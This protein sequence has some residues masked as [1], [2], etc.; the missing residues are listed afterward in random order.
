MCQIQKMEVKAFKK[1]SD[2]LWEFVLG[3]VPSPSW[4]DLSTGISQTASTETDQ[5]HLRHETE[6]KV[7]VELAAAG[8][9]ERASSLFPNGY[10]CNSILAL[11]H[12]RIRLSSQVTHRRRVTSISHL[13]K[14]LRSGMFFFA[15]SFLVAL[16]GI[17]IL[18][19]RPSIDFPMRGFF[20][21]TRVRVS[22]LEDEIFANILLSDLTYK[23]VRGSYSFENEMKREMQVVKLPHDF[24]G[25]YQPQSLEEF[26]HLAKVLIEPSMMV[27]EDDAPNP[28]KSRYAIVTICVGMDICDIAEKNQRSYATKHGYDY[29]YL[30]KDVRGV[31]PKMLKYLVL[32]WALGRGYDWIL[33]LDADAL[34]T[35]PEIT[36]P[37]LI[38]GQLSKTSVPSKDD[39]SL[40]VTRGGTWRHVN[41]LN[42]GVFFLKNTPWSLRHCYEIFTARYS[43]TRF[44]GKTLIDQ[45][46]QL[47]ILLA[48]HE[49]QWPPVEEEEVG[50]HVMV[51]PK[52]LF[53]SFR[54]AKLYS[55]ADEEEGGQWKSGDFLAHFASKQKY[56]LMIELLQ[57][58]NLPGLPPI[59][60]RYEFS[61]PAQGSSVSYEDTKAGTCWCDGGQIKCMPRFHVISSGRSGSKTVMR[62]LA[63][64]PGLNHSPHV[65]DNVRWLT[66]DTVESNDTMCNKK[67]K[68]S[69]EAMETYRG[70]PEPIYILNK[71]EES[72]ESYRGAMPSQGQAVSTC[73]F[74]DYALL[75]GKVGANKGGWCLDGQLSV[76]DL[77]QQPMFDELVIWEKGPSNVRG[78]P[79]PELLHRLQPSARLIIAL[80]DSANMTY[81]SYRRSSAFG[82]VTKSPQHFHQFMLRITQAW[83]KSHC[84]FANFDTCLPPDLTV[85]GS[86][87]AR[88]MYGEHLPLWLDSF[89][90]CSSVHLFDT[91][92]DRLEEVQRLYNFVGTP[93]VGKAYNGTTY[94]GEDE[95][96]PGQDVAIYLPI[97]DETRVL[98]ELFYL[99]SNRKVCDAMETHGCLKIPLLE[100]V[101][102]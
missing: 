100:R 25:E 68:A 83:T 78:T 66:D 48:R 21:P 92:A 6:S 59:E 93:N 27:D 74:D 77:Q 56:S 86:W 53:N 75:H 76:E 54:R 57:E 47:S 33:M 22:L 40:I 9:C 2:K 89:G 24:Q 80:R 98:L 73:T 55:K 67:R 72:R 63:G 69:E 17:L 96:F 26:Q 90:G 94:N 49:L 35:N 13:K 20:A 32:T 64:H 81:L 51:A 28:C 50:R 3:L 41:A 37:G 11:H 82:D 23:Q 101:C 8:N 44:L 97:K 43:Y 1:G 16:R 61:L 5:K 99:Q 29:L 12:C 30:S 102:A 31:P 85:A 58:E 15:M 60:Q 52:R 71:G 14:Y 38:E 4:S 10:R 7:D 19:Q 39:I 91:T 34:I 88:S 70:H 45:P 87:I 62:Y 42:N 79:L 84:N 36:L 46:V 95:K 65:N 18:R